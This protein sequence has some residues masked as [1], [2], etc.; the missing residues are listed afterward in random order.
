MLPHPP[1]PR[2]LL[3]APR[4]S[5]RVAI[6]D[7]ASARWLLISAKPDGKW[8]MAEAALLHSQNRPLEERELRQLLNS[9]QYDP[10]K[11]SLSKGDILLLGK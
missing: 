10:T 2:Q 7:I 11:E 1:P 6:P 9:L 4:F 8:D 5:L 3:P